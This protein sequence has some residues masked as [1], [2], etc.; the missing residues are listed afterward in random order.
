MPL[1]PHMN[2]EQYDN[3]DLVLF[4]KVSP[5]PRTD[6]D[7]EVLNKFLVN[8]GMSICYFH[9]IR[10]KKDYTFIFKL[11]CSTHD[12]VFLAQ[13]VVYDLLS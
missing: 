12:P 5:R 9:K 2:C 10:E 4:T 1:P 8:K 7:T 6:S 11:F 13:Y 3:R